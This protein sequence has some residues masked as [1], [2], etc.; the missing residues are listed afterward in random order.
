[1]KINLGWKIIYL[2]TE[3]SLDVL[4]GVNLGIAGAGLN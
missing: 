1:M 3:L 2:K 4:R